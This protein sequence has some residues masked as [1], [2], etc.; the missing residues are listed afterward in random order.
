[1]EHPGIQSLHWREVPPGEYKVSLSLELGEGG[2]ATTSVDVQTRADYSATAIQLNYEARMQLLAMEQAEHAL[3]DAIAAVNTFT[4][5]ERAAFRS[6][7]AAA[8]I[9]LLQPTPPL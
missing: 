6:A 3:A 5:T 1:M 7:A 2:I 9:G 4:D 8:Q